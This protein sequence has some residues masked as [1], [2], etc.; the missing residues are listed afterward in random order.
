MRVSGHLSGGAELIKKYMNGPTSFANAGVIAI[1]TMATNQGVIPNTAGVYNSAVGLCYD[2][3]TYSAAP[4]SGATAMVN[5]SC[6]PDAII[7]AV[8][9]GGQTEGTALTVCTQ[10]SAST[11]VLTSADVGTASVIGGTMWRLQAQG[12]EVDDGGW[13]PITGFSSGASL[14]AT[15]A[16]EASIAVG[17]QMLFCSW[18]QLPGDGTDTSDGNTHLEPS[19]VFTQADATIASGT[20]AS[21]HIWNLIMRSATDSEVEFT[22]RDHYLTNFQADVI[23]EA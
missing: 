13:R 19:A 18:S 17:D 22:L 12:D 21:V 4:A 8:M 1:P 10:T 15:V 9:S 2:T 5:V 20:G 11:T 14:T 6:R 23:A 16:F 7:N 3:S